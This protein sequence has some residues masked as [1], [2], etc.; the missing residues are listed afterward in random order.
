M[1]KRESNKMRATMHTGR[2]RKDGAAYSV[3]HNDRNYDL[4]KSDNVD[5]ELVHKNRYLIVD[6]TGKATTP[7]GITFDQHEHNMYQKLFGESLEIQNQRYREKSNDKYIKTLDEY[8]SSPRTCPE[9]IIM[10][11]G[12]KD[13]KIPGKVL[14]RALNVWLSEMQTRYGSNVHLLDIA[15]HVDEPGGIH[16]HVRWVYSK[17]GKDGR[18]VSQRGALSELGIER[19]DMTKP[20]SKYNNAKMAFTEQARAL[21]LDSIERSGGP[22]IIAA[23]KIPGK[24]SMTK[25]EY[26]AEK[27]RSEIIDLHTEREQLRQETEKMAVEREQLQQ[28]VETLQAEKSRLQRITERLKSSCMT[29]FK[30]LARVVCADGR[31]ALEHVKTEAQA[32]LD[33]QDELIRDEIDTDER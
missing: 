25:E 18:T 32:V 20:E 4:S 5:P 8:R 30:R 3:K 9:E 6:E 19:P 14:T 2:T 16:A 27:V 22:D 12:T 31:C 23:A 17:A 33:A 11:I 15:V 13:D 1:T 7:D 21:W 26:I 10:A 29:L 24:K 28:E